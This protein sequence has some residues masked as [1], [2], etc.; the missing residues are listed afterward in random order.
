[1]D[2]WT[3][4]ATLHAVTDGDTYDLV[5]DQ[6]FGDFTIKSIRLQGID[7]FEKRTRDGQA[8]IRFVTSWFDLYPYVAVTT[9]RIKFVKDRQTFARYVGRIH[10]L[11]AQEQPVPGADLAEVL[12]ANG[13]E[14]R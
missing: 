12:R 4:R 6:G 13:F 8:A 9:D 11:D 5:I 2:L 14:K 10:G 3:K 7:I 1:M